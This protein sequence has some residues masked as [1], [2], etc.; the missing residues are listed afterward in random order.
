[1]MDTPHIANDVRRIHPAI[2]RANQAVARPN[3]DRIG[4]GR[5]TPA[6]GALYLS[7]A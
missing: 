3:Q 5:V 2:R 4:I 7:S 1:M 6:E